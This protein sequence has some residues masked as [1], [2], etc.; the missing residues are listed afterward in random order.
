MEQQHYFNC[1]YQLA[2]Y[3]KNLNKEV[4]QDKPESAYVSSFQL[5]EGDLICLATDGLWDN[6]NDRSLL[7]LVNAEIKVIFMKLAGLMCVL[8]LKLF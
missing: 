6:L 3:P 2:I 7:Q 4:Q 8:N 5:D 1:P